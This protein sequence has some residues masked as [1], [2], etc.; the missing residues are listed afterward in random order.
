MMEKIFDVPKRV[1]KIQQNTYFRKNKKSTIPE[2]LISTRKKNKRRTRTQNNLYRKIRNTTERRKL[3][4]VTHQ[5]RIQITDA[6][7][8]N[9][10]A[11]I[12]E[13]HSLLRSA[14]LKTEDNKLLKK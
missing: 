14:D 13:K 1:E 8:E 4:I 12:A 5:I 3:Q 11:T 9:R 2:A 6:Q 10:H 7:P